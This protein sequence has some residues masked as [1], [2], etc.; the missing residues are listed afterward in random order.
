[1]LL[2]GLKS[3]KGIGPKKANEI[4]KARDG[5]RKFTT[6]M[7]KMLRDPDTVFNILFPC[8]HWWGDFYSKPNEFG[9]T[10]APDKIETISKPGEYL[11]VG[12]LIE[13]NLRDLNEPRLLARRDGRYIHENKYFLTMILEDDTESIIVSVNRYNFESIGRDIAE[14]SKVGHD[15]F[16]VKGSIKDK[17]RQVDVTQILNLNHWGAKSGIGPDMPF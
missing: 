1:M 8:E 14:N 16:L 4:L 15:W 7:I 17:W 13:C 2:G 12:K 3:I 6:G 10:K 11:L 5:K 9:L